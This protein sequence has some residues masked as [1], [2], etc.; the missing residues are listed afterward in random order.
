VTESGADEWKS[1]EIARLQL[2]SGGKKPILDRQTLLSVADMDSLDRTMVL[3]VHQLDTEARETRTL[4]AAASRS[5]GGTP[6]SG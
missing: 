2:R 1:P 6:V 4:P 5:R 3:R